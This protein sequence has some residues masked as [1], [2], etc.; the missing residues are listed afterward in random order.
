M[1]ILQ[2]KKWK[3]SWKLE[4]WRI[5]KVW[6]F[7]FFV[8]FSKKNH[9]NFDFFR[10]ISKFSNPRS[11]MIFSSI[12]LGNFREE[13]LELPPKLKIWP[14]I[15]QNPTYI[16]FFEFFSQKWNNIVFMYLILLEILCRFRIWFQIWCATNGS[17]A[18]PQNLSF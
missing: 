3:K 16:T 17:L 1:I 6:N 4:F 7:E 13:I 18:I 8:N 14:T 10:K 15:F 11:F 12:I 5:F 9:I 2:K